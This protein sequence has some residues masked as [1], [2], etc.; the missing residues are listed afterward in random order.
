[1]KSAHQQPSRRVLGRVTTDTKG[2]PGVHMEGI[3]RWVGL[4][5]TR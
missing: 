5:L 2:P 3:G 1:M 4:G